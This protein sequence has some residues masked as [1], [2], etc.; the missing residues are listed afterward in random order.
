MGIDPAF[1]RRQQEHCR[2][3]IDQRKQQQISPPPAPEAAAQPT[4][5][6]ARSRQVV[7]LLNGEAAPE[8]LFTAGFRAAIADAQ[9]RT[10]SANL[11]A[12][13]GRALAV[14]L[15]LPRDG[16]RAAFE[17]RF[18]RGLAKGA[19][20]LDPADNNRIDE[21][22]FTSV[23]WLAVA[24][25]TPEAIAADLAALPGSVNAWF[26]PLGGAPLISRNSDRPLALGSA[27][28]L[29]V[30]AALAEDVKA[31][32][33]RWSNVVPLTQ[34]SYPS[35]Q[36]QD[37]PQGA[38]VTL[39]T[40]ASLMISVS[41]NTATD[42][43][44]A[45]LGPDRII[46]LMKDSGHSD[47]AANDPFLTT[48]ELFV[49]KASEPGM[50]GTWSAQDKIE[51]QVTIA[52]VNA[53]DFI[54]PVSLDEVNA[55]FGNGPK[56]LEIEWFA[57]PADL[58]RLLAHMRK[59]ADPE[60]FAI[61]A[62]NPSAT[63]AIKANWRYIGFKGGSEPGVLNLTWLLTDKAGRDWVLTLGWN[64]PEAV[65]DEGKLEAIAQRILLLPR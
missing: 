59:T 27:F 34:R 32:K 14:S 23:D 64:N 15:L 45:V 38:P 31:G 8:E 18:E 42:Q 46:K 49:L 33:R 37:W 2:A 62:I 36:L 5:L 21:L 43:L 24:G 1:L 19:L 44:I 39:H 41:D 13:F 29:F 12:Q 63:D 47:P 30:L 55:A 20:A 28:K 11:T 9:I 52:S 54:T 57:S 7:E 35:G 26:G 3:R 6:E 40:L 4:P 58:A 22:R 56:A 60:A 53:L 25:D 65:V 61:M 17:I 10:L 50:I 48:R 16:T 51:R